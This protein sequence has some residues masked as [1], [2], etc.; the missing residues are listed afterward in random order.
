MATVIKPPRTSSLFCYIVI[1]V[2][3]CGAAAAFSRLSIISLLHFPLD[4]AWIHAVYARSFA[5]GHGFEY[6]TGRQETGATSPLWVILSSP[7]HWLYPF[8]LFKAVAAVKLICG[9]LGIVFLFGVFELAQSLGSA[10]WMSLLSALLVAIEPRVLFSVFSGMENLLLAALWIW[11]CVMLSRER[12]LAAS[13]MIGLAAVTRPEALLLVALYAAGQVLTCGEKKGRW[14]LAG[15]ALVPFL[16][17]V[18]FCVW[19]SGHP[20]PATFYLKASISSLNLQQFRVLLWYLFEQGW[21]AQ[22]VIW[23]GFIATAFLLIGRDKRNLPLFLILILSPVL[24][25]MSVTIGREVHED[26]YYWG[27]WF[28]PAFIIFVSAGVIG[29]SNLFSWAWRSAGGAIARAAAVLSLLLLAAALP[30]FTASF[31]ARSARL[32]SD[33]RATMLLTERAAEWIRDNVPPESLVGVIDAG[34]S[35]YISNRN[36][37]DIVGL[38]NSDVAFQRRPR[39]EVLQDL[40]YLVSFPGM[41]ASALRLVEGAFVPVV[42]FSIPREEY[43]ICDCRAQ[44][45]VIISKLDRAITGAAK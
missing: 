43:T 9:I 41:Y 34:A 33:A 11:A 38:N 25:A 35:R 16:L 3:F 13:I 36:I 15:L 5:F 31:A 1:A 27:R 23:T 32:E 10:R 37:V 39:S 40:T 42:S 8:G 24:Y 7:A 6:V 45:T 14:S 2:T 29:L 17:W 22:P 30:A 20:L 21:M 19:V 26:G 44:S 4:D 12:H 18:C 28:D